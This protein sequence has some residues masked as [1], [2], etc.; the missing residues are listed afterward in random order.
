M[1]LVI[2]LGLKSIRGIVYNSLGKKIDTKN[3]IIKTHINN[4][5]VEQDASEYILK[6]NK[7]LIHLKKKKLLQK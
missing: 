4:N 2:N 5:H 3:F 7:I 1:Y 6:L